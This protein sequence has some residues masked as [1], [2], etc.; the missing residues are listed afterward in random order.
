MPYSQL[1]EKQKRKNYIMMLIL[2][3][4][5]AFFFILGFIKLKGSL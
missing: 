4:L 3:G 2:F 1:H 5:V